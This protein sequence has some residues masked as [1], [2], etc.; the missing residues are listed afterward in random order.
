MEEVY[1]LWYVREWPDGDDTEL[2]IGAFASENDA[3]A[4]SEPLKLQPGFRVAPDLFEVHHYE[5]G[6]VQDWSEGYAR[7]QGDVNLAAD[8]AP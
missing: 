5:V 8:E 4:A 7:M 1:L 2:L 6:K 3:R